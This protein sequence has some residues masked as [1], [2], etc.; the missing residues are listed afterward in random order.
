MLKQAT[1]RFC[2]WNEVIQ[3]LIKFHT[4]RMKALQSNG[5]ELCCWFFYPRNTFLDITLRFVDIILQ[6]WFNVGSTGICMWALQHFTVAK[7]WFLKNPQALVLHFP[8]AKLYKLFAIWLALNQ[9]LLCVSKVPKEPDF[10][11]MHEALSLDS[12]YP[13]IIKL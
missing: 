1:H 8:W 2:T 3:T 13:S 6:P 4:H 7:T 11:C 12:I 5:L 9:W 10:V